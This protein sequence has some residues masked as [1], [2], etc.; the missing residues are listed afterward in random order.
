MSFDTLCVIFR[1][2]DVKTLRVCA[3]VSHEWNEAAR[4]ILQKNT[5]RLALHAF[6]IIDYNPNLVLAGSM[7][8]WLSLDGPTTWFPNDADLFYIADKFELAQSQRKASRVIVPK[9]NTVLPDGSFSIM[10]K[11]IEFETNRC[12]DESCEINY[13]KPRLEQIEF[14]E[15]TV[16]CV[17]T[18]AFSTVEA[19]LNNFDISASMVAYAAH[20]PTPSF[21]SA[22]QQKNILENRIANSKEPISTRF[23]IPVYGPHFAYPKATAYVPILNFKDDIV[24]IC[25]KE[26]TMARLKRYESRGCVIKDIQTATSEQLEFSKAYRTLLPLTGELFFAYTL[27]QNIWDNQVFSA[28]FHT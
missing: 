18:H 6:T 7:A 27:Q 16:Q 14:K 24:S 21:K 3:Q 11:V 26:R 9:S 22:F 8:L 10:F 15:G 19:L 20:K 4:Y 12:S 5:L 23:G 25:Q 28:S 17:L 1:Y 13:G 2:L